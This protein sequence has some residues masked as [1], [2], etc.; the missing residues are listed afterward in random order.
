MPRSTQPQSLC[1]AELRGI[2]RL[3][4]LV[5]IDLIIR[6]ARDEV[7]LGLR[8][9]EP[10]KGFYF[11]PGGMIRKGERL[12]EAFARV[13]KDETGL[14][15]ISP[16]L[17]SSVRTSI[18]TIITVLQK[19]VMA[20][21]MSRTATQ[22]ASKTSRDLYGTVSTASLAGGMKAR[23]SH[24]IP[25]TPM[26]KPISAE[27]KADRAIKFSGSRRMGCY[28]RWLATHP[29]ATAADTRTITAI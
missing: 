28:R 8:S 3:A 16:K 23:C 11:V 20:Q 19:R 2:V 25:F 14:T 21:T 24:W 10:A 17:D 15:A 6:N 1:H 4:P 9:N 26:P 18:S 12:R 5:A 7:L 13:L 27:L 22:S 29:L